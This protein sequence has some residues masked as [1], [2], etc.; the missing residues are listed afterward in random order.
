MKWW[1]FGKN[2][3]EYG[4]VPMT[5][6]TRRA[7]DRARCHCEMNGYRFAAVIG[8]KDGDTMTKP[9]TNLYVIDKFIKKK[10]LITG[11]RQLAGSIDDSHSSQV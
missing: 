8:Y 2:K 4:S 10:N 7:L 5:D 1:P 11:L 6:Y 9:H 3:K